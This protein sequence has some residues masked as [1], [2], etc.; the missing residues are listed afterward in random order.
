MQLIVPQKPRNDPPAAHLGSSALLPSPRPDLQQVL[1]LA[2]KASFPVE[3]NKK[4]LSNKLK[5][6]KRR[7]EQPGGAGSTRCIGRA[8]ETPEDQPCCCTYS[9]CRHSSPSSLKRP[10]KLPLLFNFGFIWI[11]KRFLFHCFEKRKKNNANFPLH[12]HQ[13]AGV[14]WSSGCGLVPVCRFSTLLLP[15]PLQ[16]SKIY[17]VFISFNY[18][19]DLKLKGKEKKSKTAQ[20]GHLGADRWG[21]PT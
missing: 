3:K 5:K 7:N 9:C 11:L 8:A 21:A 6:K 4:A 16:F 12:G 1:R 10:L 13:A 17:F 2:Q 14:R 15:F 20:V 19:K 18:F